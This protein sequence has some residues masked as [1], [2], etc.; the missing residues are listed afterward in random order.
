MRSRIRCANSSLGSRLLGNGFVT[1][2]LLLI[3]FA[4]LLALPFGAVPVSRLAEF[5]SAVSAESNPVTIGRV[6]PAGT[7]TVTDLTQKI[8]NT[9]GCSLPEAIYSSEYADNIAPD[10]A[11]PGNYIIGTPC[12]KG[13]GDDTIVLPA[14]SVLLM[15]SIMRDLQ[16]PMGPTATPVINSKIIIEANG[17][18][19]EHVQNGV[20]F[21]A[22]AINPGESLTIRNAY[23]KGFTARGGNGGSGGGGG[24]GAGGAIYV[25]RGNLTLESCTFEGNGAMGGNGSEGKFSARLVPL[26]V[27]SPGGGGGGLGGN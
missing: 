12:A 8:S 16:N 3:A 9:G 15:S 23:I 25:E 24:M 27:T 21:R 4:V 18:R 11:N 14:G 22:F 19:L 13:T 26:G 17:S 2:S 1:R 6:A 5:A 10:P 7:I 20:N